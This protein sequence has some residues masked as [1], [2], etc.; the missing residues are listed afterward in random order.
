[1]PSLADRSRCLAGTEVAEAADVEA[2][3]EENPGTFV[4]VTDEEVIEVEVIEVEVIEVE[5]IE[6]E[7]FEEGEIELVVARMLLTTLSGMRACPSTAN[8]PRWLSQQVVF[9]SALVRAQ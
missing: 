5:V 2:D 4:G 6:V 8:C 7:V 9:T 3:A 1:M